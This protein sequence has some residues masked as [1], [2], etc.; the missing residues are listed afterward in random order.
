MVS[1]AVTKL[2]HNRLLRGVA[3][4]TASLLILCVVGV[5]TARA[6]T[7]PSAQLGDK[8][9]R[10]DV[11]A[12][13]ADRE[14]GLSGR[15]GL[16]DDQAMLFVFDA[17]GIHCI[18]MKDMKFPIDIV[19]LNEARNVVKLA[20][21]VTPDTYPQNFC[22]DSPAAFVIELPEGTAEQQQLQVGQSVQIQNI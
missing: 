11:A 14:R 15:S 9:F 5:R 22:P 17:P 12:T 1:A 21:R 20:A 7:S 16:A 6:P 10:L 8:T 18:W 2:A 19:W 13:V 3:V 4:L